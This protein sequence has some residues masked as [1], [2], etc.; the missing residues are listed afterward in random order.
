MIFCWRWIFK[1]SW[2][3]WKCRLHSALSKILEP[4]MN[5]FKSNSRIIKN[6]MNYE[7]YFHYLRSHKFHRCPHIIW[8]IDLIASVF[9]LYPFLVRLVYR[10]V[11]TW[12]HFYSRGEG[13]F[14]ANFVTL[15]LEPEPSERRKSVQFNEEVLI[16]LS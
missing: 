11:W 8:V 12:K 9:S 1:H 7:L 6:I 3:I 2:K 13:L 5:V 15:S 14:P 4:W 10:T 16:N